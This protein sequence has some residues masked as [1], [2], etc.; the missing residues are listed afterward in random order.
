MAISDMPKYAHLGQIPSLTLNSMCA[1]MSELVMIKPDHQ[2]TDMS[3]YT[4][5]VDLANIENPVISG[6]L[7]ITISRSGAHPDHGIWD[8][9]I[10]DMVPG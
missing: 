6:N 4:R 1:N 2:I 3:K 9:R 10:L 8:P 7:N 5:L